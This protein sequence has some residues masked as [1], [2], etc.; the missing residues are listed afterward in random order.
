MEYVQMRM[1]SRQEKKLTRQIDDRTPDLDGI[2]STLRESLQEKIDQR[3]AAEADHEDRP[4]IIHKEQRNHH[5]LA[6]I[7]DKHIGSVQP[8]AA[9]ADS[10][11]KI[12]RPHITIVRDNDFPVGVLEMRDYRTFDVFRIH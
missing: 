5:R 8:D 1:F 10:I 6:V 12:E 9:L 2:N 3:A 4:W 7:L 11:A